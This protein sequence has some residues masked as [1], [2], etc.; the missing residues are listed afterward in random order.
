MGLGRIWFRLRAMT[1]APNN[2]GEGN[3]GSNSI[4]VARHASLAPTGPELSTADSMQERKLAVFDIVAQQYRQDLNIYWV[5]ANFFLFVQSGLLAFLTT[6]TSSAIE[7]S[8]INF[9][10]CGVGLSIAIVW[11]AVSKSSLYWI[12][13]WR[14]RVCEIDEDINPF[15]SF[16]VEGLES[17]HPSFFE[18]LRP[19]VIT[20]YLPIVF[21]IAWLVLAAEV[22]LN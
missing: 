15:R 3:I 8:S 13:V 22:T 1:E 5:R 4:S 7:R 10:V 2:S 21:I 16:S 6:S 12:G 20:G 14:K 11:Y 17:E 9:M 19:T 18:R